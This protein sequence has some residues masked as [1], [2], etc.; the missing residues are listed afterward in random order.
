MALSPAS[1]RARNRAI[2]SHPCR[3]LVQRE[4]CTR[5]KAKEQALRVRQSLCY[6][7]SQ[8]IISL[9]LS[10]FEGVLDANRHKSLCSHYSNG[11]EAFPSPEQSAAF[12]KDGLSQLQKIPSDGRLCCVSLSL[13][14]RGLSQLL[15]V[16]DFSK[17][18]CLDVSNNK[19]EC[20]YPVRLAANLVHLNARNNLLKSAAELSA[21]TKLQ[22]ADLRNN[23]IE[24]LGNRLASLATGNLSSNSLLR[25]LD[26][27]GNN[28][29]SLEPLPYLKCLDTLNAS[30][31]L[32]TN[33]QGIQGAPNVVVLHAEGNKLESLDPLGLRRTPFLRE[34]HVQL[35][36]ELKVP[37]QLAG[38]RTAE[39]LQRLQLSPGPITCFPH[40][41]LHCVHMLPQLLQLDH[42]PITVEEQL[43][44][45]E[46]F[47]DLL[48]ARRR[49]WES[50]IPEEPF[51]DRRLVKLVGAGEAI[52]PATKH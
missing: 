52:S 48:Y 32:L 51:V 33:L 7:L 15:L 3:C 31:N 5:T 11:Q 18:L 30:N 1:N 46:A 34:L 2:S 9:L 4:N 38:L 16:C 43:A 22:T 17:L 10:P 26:I 41:R 13:S 49:V 47:G 19:L 50:L 20:L 25:E 44:A 35:N 39:A 8:L 28:I 6:C 21:N 40:W 23:H 42:A 14:S 24:E 36:P 45:A 12:L 29:S 37:Q 27:G